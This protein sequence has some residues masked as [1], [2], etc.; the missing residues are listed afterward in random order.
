MNQMNPWFSIWSKPRAT[1]IQVISEDPKRGMWILAWIYGMLAF[2]NAFQGMSI[3][4]SLSLLPTLCVALVFAPLWGMLSFWV[5]SWILYGVGKF[6][7]GKGNAMLIRS[8]YAWSCAPLILSVITW[9]AMIAIFRIS[10]FQNFPE[11][12]TLNEAQIFMLFGFLA[13]KV[14][15]TIWSFVIFINALAEVQQFSI[16]RAILNIVLSWGVL[17]AFATILWW[18]M[19]L[20]AH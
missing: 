19:S 5:W 1:I 11:N 9:F 17:M 14:T 7:K 8:A 10:L 12:Y 15:I 2:F 16:G 18:G 3:G 4:Y 20:L 6:L 13:F